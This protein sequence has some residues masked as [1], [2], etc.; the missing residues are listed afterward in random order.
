MT[1]FIKKLFKFRPVYISML[2]IF[3]GMVIYIHGIPFL[4]YM[5]LKTIDLRFAS[6]GKIKPGSDVVLATIHEKSLAAEGKWPWPR[7]KIANLVAKL[8]DA[9][10]KVIA[11]DI[12][13]AEPDN[14]QLIETL[15]DIE[16]TIRS[17]DIRNAD[18]TSYIHNLKIKS[19]NDQRL[20][21]VIKQDSSKVI[22]GYYFHTDEQSAKHIGIKEL[23]IHAK[24]ISGSKYKIFR[25]ASKQAQNVAMKDVASLPAFAPQS[26]IELISSASKYSG[27]INMLQ[28]SDGVVRRMPSV[29]KFQDALYAPLSLIAISAYL[30]TSIELTITELGI[31]DTIR[32]GKRFIPNDEVGQILINYRG[33]PNTFT[34]I[35]VT[36]ILH[37]KIP[38]TVFKDKIVLVGVTATGAYDMRVTPFGTVFPGLEIHAN[39]IDT[40]L[41]QEYLQQPG[42]AIIFDL[43][44]MIAAGLFLGIVLP[45][46]GVGMGALTGTSV[47]LG[48]I[49]VCLYFFS[50]K[51]WILNLVYPLSVIV[52]VYVGI[53]A[54]KYLV[55][56]KQK[57]FIRGA[58]STYLA[59]S[60]V[61]QLIESPEKLGLGGEQRVITAFFSDVQ[62]FT[63][64]S[65]QLSPREIVELLN[66]FLTEMTDIILKYEG[67]V[68]K[69]EGDA[70]IAFFGAPNDLKNHAGIA[71][72]ACIDMQKRLAELRQIWKSQNKPE[73]KMRIG[74]CTGPAVVGNM[75]SRN[76]MDYTMMGD[77]VNTAA[78]LEEA[79]KTFGIYTLIGETTYK[80]MDNN[81]LTRE[82]DS[83]KV[84]GKENPITIYEALG[85]PE[86]F[87]QSF[88]DTLS[89]YA[90]GLTAYKNREWENAI[91]HFQSALTHKSNDGPSLTL[92]ARCQEY[93][94]SPPGYDWDGSYALTSK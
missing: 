43:F 47:F 3:A 46:V 92:L 38:D 27:F 6:R 28:D 9:G 10:A 71:C 64:I 1:S 79:N 90:S 45:R 8:S 7:S 50:Q 52:L 65:E 53:T 84:V 19:D 87:D 21:D 4:D 91:S 89:H 35:P 77:T 20:A 93:K 83:V 26:T 72:K 13:F 58:F 68:D 54:Y 70:I 22:I 86:D 11:F 73:L 23:P 51:G 85:Y 82:I 16:Q 88:K 59:P 44:A 30:N 15:N 24:N 80:A 32:L 39:F 81:I 57:R 56:A 76:R 48:Y 17:L 5:E 61:N 60:V 69:F 78:R 2:L 66:E 34:H 33:P 29:I 49:F 74:L 31:I 12:F 18:I 55:E 94:L 14:K 75:G 41:S 25:Y 37:G 42:W 40:V 67:T 62:E 36:D 63:S